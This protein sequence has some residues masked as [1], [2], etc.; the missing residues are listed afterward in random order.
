MKIPIIAPSLLAADWGCFKEEVTEVVNAGADW[1]HVDVMDGHFV[2]PITFGPGVV[3][4]I[5]Q[6]TT[7][8]IDVHLMIEKAE[9]QVEAFAKAGADIITVHFEACPHLHRVIQQIRECGAKPGVAINPATPVELIQHVLAD[10]HLLLIMTVNPGW[11]GQKF[12][13]GSEKKIKKAAEM[14]KSGGH[15]VSIEVDGGIDAAT[16]K[17]CMAAGADVLVSGTY[18]FGHENYKDAIKSLR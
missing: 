5:R 1:I 15:Q 9:N 13:A 12:I 4:A 17:S 2:P 6:T 14:I 3:R 18:I 7:C 11:G 10:V 16:A 8:T